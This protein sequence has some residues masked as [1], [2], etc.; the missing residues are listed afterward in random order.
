[1]QVLPLATQFAI[2]LLLQSFT[3]SPLQPLFAH[4]TEQ[5]FL[6]QVT[7]IAMSSSESKRSGI[8]IEVGVDIKI[9]INHS[10]KK[11]TKIIR[12]RSKQIQVDFIIFVM[13]NLHILLHKNKNNQL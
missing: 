6:G 2:H 7:G 1:M 11:S 5:N 9:N 12:K 8:G 10:I 13:L 3:V 4:F